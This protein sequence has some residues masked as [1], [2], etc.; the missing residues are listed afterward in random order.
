MEE[1]VISFLADLQHTRQFS[2][3]TILA[4]QGDLN[5]YASFLSESGEPNYLNVDYQDLRIYLSYLYDKGYS[6]SSISRKL[7]SLRS[8]YQFLLSQSK[9]E[10][11][12][13]TY[14]QIRQKNQKLPR[15]YYEKEM[16]QLF[17]V[18]YAGD[19]ALDYRNCALLELMYATGIRVSEATGIRLSDIDMTT[20]ILLV[21]GKGNKERYV[22]F[23]HYASEAVQHY[24][25]H[26]RPQLMKKAEHSYLFVNAKGQPLT[27]N[28]VRYIY[29]ELVKKT[30]LTSDIHPHM[31][32]HTF[33]THLLNNG[34]DM[35]TVQEL[36]GHESLS[37]TQIYAHVTTENLQS[38]YRHFHPR[39]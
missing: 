39:A 24:I 22:P 35:R 6:R 21:H 3:K 11:N 23:G 18:V 2:E 8:F 26:A 36:L 28:G 31:L 7:S 30:T 13:V 10:E 33:A 12:P 25:N 4:Y 14:V 19:R 37:S 9:V 5:D 16:T 27:T 34:A 32:R 15:F 20:D 17:D 29:K 1:D 38:T